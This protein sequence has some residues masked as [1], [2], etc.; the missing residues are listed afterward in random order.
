MESDECTMLQNLRKQL[1]YER[2]GDTLVG[3]TAI[4]VWRVRP[5]PE[6]LLSITAGQ[7]EEVRRVRRGVRPLLTGD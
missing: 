6:M 1:L 4:A 5:G 7:V 2:I 3:V